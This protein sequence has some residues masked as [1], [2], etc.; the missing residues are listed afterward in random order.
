MGNENCDEDTKTWAC[1]GQ[2]LYKHTPSGKLYWRTEV[3]GKRTFHVLEADNIK[4]AREEIE[5]LKKARKTPPKAAQATTMGQVI[6]KYR[7]DGYPDKHKQK[8]PASTEAEEERHCVLLMEHWEA[9][10]ISSSGP[11]ECDRYHTKR[12]GEIKAGCEGNRTVDRE[13]NTLNNACRWAARSEFISSN[14]VADRPRYQP[15]N[16]VKHCR[17]FMPSSAEELH[18]NAKPLFQHPHSVVLAFQMLEE[19]MT[20]LRTIEVLKWGTEQF[21]KPTVDGKNINVW[22]CKGQHANNPFVA[23][24]PGLV[25]VRTAHQLWLAAN[26]PDATT[27]FPSHF[28]GCISKA[29]LGKALRRLRKKLTK[30]LTSHGMRAFYVLIRRSQGAS[31]EQIAFE[32]GHSSNGACIKTTYGSAPESWENGGGPNL[33]WL[34]EVPAWAELEKNGWKFPKPPKTPEVSKV[35]KPPVELE[36]AA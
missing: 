32:I 10:L 27:A 25:A 12:I 34:P 1:K 35:P 4:L 20:G 17:E 26:Y 24:H 3:N 28:G 15:A 29:A 36:K 6:N 8:R 19:A 18:T 30:K 31:D 13:L 14:P 16:K 11:A 5:A 22:R 2:G 9:V 23:L 33:S 21:G 7:A